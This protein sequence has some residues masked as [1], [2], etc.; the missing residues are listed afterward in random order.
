MKEL[1][2]DPYLL[3]PWLKSRGLTPSHFVPALSHTWHQVTPTLPHVQLILRLSRQ[4]LRALAQGGQLPKAVTLLK[5]RRTE[6]D[7]PLPPSLLSAV[8]EGCLRGGG[9]ERAIKLLDGIRS[10]GGGWLV[11]TE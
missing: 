3:P 2:G 5:A 11:D 10:V 6:V 7:A 9:L 4:V 8:L 1:S